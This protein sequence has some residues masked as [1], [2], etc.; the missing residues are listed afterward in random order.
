MHFEVPA[1]PRSYVF[2]FILLLFQPVGTSRACETILSPFAAS[3]CHIAI[4]TEGRC[5]LKRASRIRET[6]SASLR[7]FK[8]TYCYT[9]D[10]FYR[11]VTPFAASNSLR[12]LPIDR[13]IRHAISGQQSYVSF[14]SFVNW[15]P[16]IEIAA[17]A[18]TADPLIQNGN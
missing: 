18:E 12:R 13:L 15:G 3:T 14:C 1:L 8:L 17:F 16:P 7:E 2:Y 6:W 10:T 5:D 4:I 11:S 9:I